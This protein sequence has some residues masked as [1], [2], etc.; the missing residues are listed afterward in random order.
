MINDGA[1]IVDI[2]GESTRP[3]SKIVQRGEEW[4]RIENIII[5]IKKNFSKT[6]LS[7]DTRKS[8]VM[9]KGIKCGINIINDVSGLEFDKKSFSIINYKK[10]PFI[11]H[12]MQGTPETMQKNPKYVDAI[13]DIY[14][15]FE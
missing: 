9:K 14:D 1:S 4:K 3:G 13:F 2:G 8:D 10:I 11:L 6:P 7:L 12:H 15:F 5:K